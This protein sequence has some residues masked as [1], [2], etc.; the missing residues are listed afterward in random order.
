VAKVPCLDAGIVLGMW[1][2]CFDD[3]YVD[4]AFLYIAPTPHGLMRPPRV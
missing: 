4:E 3:L 2:S 1:A